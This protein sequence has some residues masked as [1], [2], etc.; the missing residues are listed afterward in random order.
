M[1]YYFKSHLFQSQ[2]MDFNLLYIHIWPFHP[3][4]QLEAITSLLIHS[5][6]HAHQPLDMLFS[7]WIICEFNCTGVCGAD[8]R[9]W[10]YKD[11]K[12][13]SQGNAPIKGN[14]HSIIQHIR[15]CITIHQ[16]RQ[17]SKFLWSYFMKNTYIACCG[18]H[19]PN[20]PRQL[21]AQEERF[22]VSHRSCEQK[23][24]FTERRALPLEEKNR[25]SEC[26]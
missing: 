18:K 21:E 13:V 1:F 14:G 10:Q 15:A 17:Q 8:V 26:R 16:N 25:Q 4:W 2:G 19:K 20:L 11:W 24:G 23:T 22:L 7:I 3:L 6:M 9:P 5:Q 12:T